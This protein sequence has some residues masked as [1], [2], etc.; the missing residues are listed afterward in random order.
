MNTASADRA[1]RSGG[2][3]DLSRMTG[4]THCVIHMGFMDAE[5]R[6]GKRDSPYFGFCPSHFLPP[7]THIYIY[8]YI[9]IYPSSKALVPLAA[10]SKAWVCGRS[11]DGT[12]GSTPAD[13]MDVSLSLS[14]LEFCVMSG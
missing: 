2:S 11:I 3:A 1:Y 5:C 8:I 13:G 14:L 6:C 9:Y 7:L 10:W 12:A 4:F